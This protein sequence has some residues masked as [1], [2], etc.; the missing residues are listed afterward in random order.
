MAQTDRWTVAPGQLRIAFAIATTIRIRTN[1][2][3]TLRMKNVRLI[4]NAVEIEISTT[5][6]DGELK[7]ENARRSQLIECSATAA[8]IRDWKLDRQKQLAMPDDY[9]F[10]DP[11]HGGKTYRLGQMRVLLNRL[12]KVATGDRSVSVHRAEPAPGQRGNFAMPPS[13][14]CA[15]DVNAF[16]ALS[17]RAGHGDASTTFLN[18]VHRFEEAIRSGIDTAITARLQWPE[19]A[20]FV[21]MSHSNYRQRLSRGR[22]GCRILTSGSASSVSSR[23]PC[24]PWSCPP[25]I[26]GSSPPM[27]RLLRTLNAQQQALSEKSSIS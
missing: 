3:L 26:P 4:D 6:F 15:H 7:S 8:L 24:Q 16:D 27:R 5:T 2:L 21:N 1:E 25:P 12:V 17:T 13:S 9:L 11:H 20:P 19:M 23:P 14:Q 18:Y 22:G 10:G